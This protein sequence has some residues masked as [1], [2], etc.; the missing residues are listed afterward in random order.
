MRNNP[1]CQSI[2]LRVAFTVLLLSAFAG[3]DVS[4]V[5][6]VY[7]TTAGVDLKAAPSSQGSIRLSI[8][9]DRQVFA[10]VPRV[11]G[12]TDGDAMSV[13][14]ASRVVLNGI[15]TDQF[16]HLVATGSPAVALATK[17][18]DLAQIATMFFGDS[19][20]GASSNSG[21]QQTNNPVGGSKGGQPGGKGAKP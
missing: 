11:N 3:C 15:S 9:Y 7:D 16:G 18:E 13:T 20:T 2:L 8:G 12:S 1:A 10:V 5:A 21:Q 14:S 17:P 6:Y 19:D 4:H